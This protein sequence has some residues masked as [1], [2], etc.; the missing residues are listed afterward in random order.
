[1]VIH[2]IN[3]GTKPFYIQHRIKSRAGLKPAEKI[4]ES[5]EHLQ[6]REIDNDNLSLP[7]ITK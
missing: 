2:G 7:Y 6:Q 4:V 5:E 1:M 3:F